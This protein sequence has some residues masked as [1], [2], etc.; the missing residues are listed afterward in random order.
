MS[1]EGLSRRRFL[2]VAG[3][4]TGA[5][6]ASQL[7]FAKARTAPPRFTGYPFTLG[8]AS[9]DP[10]PDGVVL[11][12]RLAPGRS[13]ARRHAGPATSRSTGRSPRTSVRAVVAGGADRARPPSAHSVHVDVAGLEPGREYFYRF[14]AGGDAQPGRPHPDRAG[15]GRGRPRWRFAFASLP[16]LPARLLQRLPALAEEDLDLVL[17]LGDY[18]YEYDR[19]V[20]PARATCAATRPSRRPRRLPDRYAQY[21]TDPDLQAA[22]ARRPW[23]VTW[24]DHEVEN[25]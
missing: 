14:R 11:W 20:R 21:K 17:H 6:V 2:T 8:V 25:N 23:I 15:A 1:K 10:T 13:R 7:P 18:I 5:V 16:A 24:D 12:T 4:A 9:G 19:R 22:H 3:T